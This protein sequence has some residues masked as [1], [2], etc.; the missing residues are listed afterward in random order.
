MPPSHRPTLQRMESRR[1]KRFSF[2]LL[3]AAITLLFVPSALASSETVVSVAVPGDGTYVAGQN[4]DF[5]VTFSGVVNVNTGGGTPGISLTIG[6]HVVQADYNSG[7]GTTDLI[8][9]YTVQNGDLDTNGISV[10]SAIVLNGGTIKDGG[11]VDASLTLHGVGSTANVLVDAVLPTVS[12]I[13]VPASGSYDAG[14]NLDFTVHMSKSVTVD[15]TGGTPGLSLTV[16]A[17][18][19]SADYLSGSGTSSLVFRYT[20]QP[21]DNDTDGVSVDSLALNGGRISDSDGNDADL[22]LHNVGS[23]SSVLV[24]TTQPTV[25]S[26]AAPADGTYGL[27][28]PLD[29]KVVFDEKMKATGSPEIALTVGAASREA[30][31]HSGNGTATLDFRYT[32][33]AG[34]ADNDGVSVGALT[35]NGGT[36]ND[37]A[38]NAADLTLN[39]VAATANVLV[40]TTQPTVT[41][42]SVPSRGTYTDGQTLN[43][44]VTFSKSVFVAGQPPQLG[45]T[46]GSESRDATYSS[47]TGSATL[48]FSYTVSSGDVDSDG[49]TLGSI[50]LNG[51]SI[52]DSYGNPAILTLHGVSSTSGV[53]VSDPAPVAPSAPPADTSAPTAPAQPTASIVNVHLQLS[54]TAST[55]NTAVTGYQLSINGQV[56]ATFTGTSYSLPIRTLI[57]RPG[58]LVVELRAFDAAGNLSAPVTFTLTRTHVPAGEPSVIPNW[59]W[60]LARW[61]GKSKTSRGPRPHT[62][63]PV[64]AWYAKWLVWHKAPTSVTTS[65]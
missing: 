37:L 17:A 65:S 30:T 29:F 25:S 8:F 12:S 60:H 20:V 19:V 54:F 21:G 50:S 62:P 63:I 9:R 15:T 10:G 7:S 28:K 27:T 61:Q 1:S 33:Q 18:S 34:D 53:L 39:N 64:P 32:P 47:G 51:G 45:L 38:G 6:S 36:V 16:G 2:A 56:V 26:V 14:K 35:L 42:V 49:I 44:K 22:T 5:V 11:S 57:P 52:D 24:D 23:T 4:L 41:A 48:T 43:F 13:T 58:Q 59:A 40:N 3:L 31:Y 46:V 55:D